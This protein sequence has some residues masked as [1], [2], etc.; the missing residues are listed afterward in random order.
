MIEKDPKMLHAAVDFL[1]NVTLAGNVIKSY[2][3]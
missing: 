2:H 3:Q 1:Q